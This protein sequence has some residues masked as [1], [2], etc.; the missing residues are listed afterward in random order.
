VLDRSLK[1]SEEADVFGL[2]VLHVFRNRVHSQIMSGL[3]GADGELVDG[4]DRASSLVASVW[5][6]PGVVG[7]CQT[8]SIGA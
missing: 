2:V 5:P 8:S 3:T 1:A 7:E 6:A 4:Q